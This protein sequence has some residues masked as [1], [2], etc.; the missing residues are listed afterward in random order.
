MLVSE[1]V[2]AVAEAKG[3]V[4][5]LIVGKPG[6]YTFPVRASSFDPTEN[7]FVGTL[8]PTYV[9]TMTGDKTNLGLVV[10]KFVPL[11]T[12][13]IDPYKAY[14]P[15]VLKNGI[16]SMNIALESLTG[17]NIITEDTDDA[18]YSVS[19]MKVNRPATKGIYIQNS[20]KVVVK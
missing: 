17:L 11:N 7:L 5:L 2:Q 4:G 3:G 6:T 15:I 8:A 12:G 9:E 10:T 16:E 20:R 18:W 19:G 14:L 13:V 1:L